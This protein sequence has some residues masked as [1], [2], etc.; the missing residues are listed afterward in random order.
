MAASWLACG[1]AYRNASR[2]AMRG[3]RVCPP[4]NRLTSLIQNVGDAGPSSREACEPSTP[5]VADAPSSAVLAAVLIDQ[6]CG[7]SALSPLR[8][9]RSE[10]HL[11]V[12]SVPLPWA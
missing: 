11:G 12:P 1:Q 5:W 3:C 9:A 10:L 4:T 8:R 6:N 7:G 2:S